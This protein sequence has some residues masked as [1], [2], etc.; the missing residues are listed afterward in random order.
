MTLKVIDVSKHQ[1][2]IDWEKVKPHIDGAILRCGYG[3]DIQ[4][5]DDKY[6]KRN[7][8]ECTRLGI[9]FGVYIYSYAKN[10]E[11]A[12]SEAAHTLRLINGYKLSYPVY[13]DLEENGTQSGAI[14]RA[15]VFGDIIE[16]AGYWCGVYASLSWWN[17]YLKGLNRFTKWIAQWSSKCTYTGSHLDMWQYSEKGKIPGISGN[18][19]MNYCYRD[20]PAEI[21]N[22]NSDP[23]HDPEPLPVKKTTDELAQEV[24]DGKWGNGAERKQ[25]LTAAGYDYDVV[26]NA[27]NEKLKEQPV[28]HTV[29]AGETLSYIASKYGTYYTTLAILNGIKNPDL[30]Y[31]GQRIRIK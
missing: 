22:V 7:A 19:D 10:V 18:V 8:D 2:V 26:Q 27:V 28:Y 1:G 5:Q 24:L 21:L 11:S 17:N 16:E 4:S 30:I 14:E 9:P 15:N 3:M 29:Q 23:V 31:A 13:L 25:K 6:F 20:F 12:K